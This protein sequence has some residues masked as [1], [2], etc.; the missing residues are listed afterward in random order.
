[1]GVD[2]SFEDRVRAFAE[3]EKEMRPLIAAAY[4]AGSA[5]EIDFDTDKGRLRPGR[6]FVGDWDFAHNY[7]ALCKND[8][9]IVFN[10]T[11]DKRP[12]PHVKRLIAYYRVDI[13][14]CETQDA[15]LLALLKKEKTLEKLHAALVHNNVLLHCHQG[16][17]RSATVA[18]CYL[19]KYYN[20]TRNEAVSFIQKSRPKAFHGN[21]KVR[22]GAFFT[23][24]DTLQYY[25]ESR[26][27]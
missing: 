11:D 9:G 5:N 18:A 27:E 8:I 19:I 15:A 6:L 14:D 4:P 21:K 13:D 3:Q 20:F 12:N 10:C 2:R 23:F 7:Y 16:V 17:S 1:M 24:R 26:T 22:G 25:D